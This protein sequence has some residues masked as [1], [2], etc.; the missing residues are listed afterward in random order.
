MDAEVSVPNETGGG[1]SKM[2]AKRVQM[3]VSRTRVTEYPSRKA[4]QPSPARVAHDLAP[5]LHSPIRH[6]KQNIPDPHRPRRRQD[7]LNAIE[8]ARK[9]EADARRAEL[10]AAADPRENIRSF[11]AT[12]ETQKARVERAVDGHRTAVGTPDAKP[13]D[14]LRAALDAL[15]TDIIAMERSVAEASYFLPPYDSRCAALRF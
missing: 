10:D 8:E 2:E 14:E 12:F 3:M 7:R 5:D 13:P 11:L 1:Q 6:S 15:Q 4:S 9:A